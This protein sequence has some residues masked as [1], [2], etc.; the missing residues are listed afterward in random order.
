MVC[1]DL[2]KLCKRVCLSLKVDFEK[3]SRDAYD[4]L[5]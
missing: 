4:L 1:V 5:N 3:I 2:Q